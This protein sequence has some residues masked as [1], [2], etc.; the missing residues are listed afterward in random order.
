VLVSLIYGCYVGAVSGGR[1]VVRELSFQISTG[2]RVQGSGFGCQG[3]DL[4]RLA[5]MV[6]PQPSTLNPQ[7]FI[8]RLKRPPPNSPGPG[9]MAPFVTVRD[10]FPLL[11]C[12]DEMLSVYLVAL[13]SYNDSCKNG[14]TNSGFRV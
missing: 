12:L 7:P 5:L 8:A 14:A 4:G 1:G 3:R 9:C 10:A 13:V 6:N 11:D 2:F